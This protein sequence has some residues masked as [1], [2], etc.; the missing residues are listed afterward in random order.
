MG[1]FARP[2]GIVLHLSAASRDREG[3]YRQTCRKGA[4]WSESPHALSSNAM[5]FTREGER[6]ELY[7]GETDRA[8]GKDVR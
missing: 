4:R 1:A 2:A 6:G 8:D 3:T 7:S 5:V